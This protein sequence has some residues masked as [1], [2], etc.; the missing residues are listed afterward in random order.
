MSIVLSPI[1]QFY[2]NLFLIKLVPSLTGFDN[3][4]G[5]WLF[6]GKDFIVD[7]GLAVTSQQ[8]IQAL[9]KLNI[10]HLNY[11]LL[12]HIHIDHAGAIGDIAAHFPH[13]PVIIC[14]AK[15]NFLS[16]RPFPLMG[17]DM[18]NIRGKPPKSTT[19]LLR[20]LQTILLVQI[21]LHR[22]A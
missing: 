14:H 16:G 15:G 20:Y 7:V 1:T 4:I 5:V 17:E 12:T 6:K 19:R 9:N 11:I 13:T 8:L 10:D 3:F 21:G 22:P 2:H 18:E